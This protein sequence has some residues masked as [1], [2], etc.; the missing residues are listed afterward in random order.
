MEI[1]DVNRAWLGAQNVI[2]KELDKITKIS[3]MGVSKTSYETA[4]LKKHIKTMAAD[5]YSCV[6]CL[7]GLKCERH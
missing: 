7:K 2:E 1:K 6:K 3:K 5:F 4:F